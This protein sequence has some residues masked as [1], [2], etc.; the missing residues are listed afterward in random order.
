MRDDL[1][2]LQMMDQMY[3]DIYMLMDSLFC[4]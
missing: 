1:N 4:H 3:P 2:M